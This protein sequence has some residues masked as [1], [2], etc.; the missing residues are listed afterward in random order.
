MVQ[1]LLGS[2]FSQILSPL[3]LMYSAVCRGLSPVCS[4]S[5]SLQLQK[6]DLVA[7][8]DPVLGGSRE[9]VGCVRHKARMHVTSP[10]WRQHT[11]SSSALPAS[12]PLIAWWTL[13]IGGL[14]SALLR[15]IVLSCIIE[16]FSTELNHR[17][18]YTSDCILLDDNGIKNGPTRVGM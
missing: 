10:D 4:S 17:F 1:G 18:F 9:N 14:Y 8:M 15:S 7:S 5:E 2:N 6:Y 16:Q 3:S 11:S 13:N 12:S